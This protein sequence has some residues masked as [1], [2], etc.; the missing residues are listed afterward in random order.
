MI[1]VDYEHSENFIDENDIF[2]GFNTEFQCC[3]NFGWY[4]KDNDCIDDAEA[5]SENEDVVSKID[6]DMEGWVFDTSYCEWKDYDTKTFTCVDAVVFRIIKEDQEK[7][8]FLFNVGNGM[9]AHDFFFGACKD[10]HANKALSD[11]KVII[12]QGSV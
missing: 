6:F 1:K 9:Y 3:E 10:A 5:L 11:D 12:E 4:F 7:F 2:V 8:L